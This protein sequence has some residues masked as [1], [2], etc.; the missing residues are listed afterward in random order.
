MGFNSGFKGLIL[1]SN[2]EGHCLDSNSLSGVLNNCRKHIYHFFKYKN[3][4][5]F[6]AQFII[7]FVVLL[8]RDGDFFHSALTGFVMK[9]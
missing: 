4:H 8:T 7:V 6:A 3:L 9:L 2:S 1:H 5:F